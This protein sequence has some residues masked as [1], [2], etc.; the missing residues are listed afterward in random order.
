V[1]AFNVTDSGDL[2]GRSIYLASL[3]SP[4]RVISRKQMLSAEEWKV[5]VP[6]YVSIYKHLV[7]DYSRHYLFITDLPVDTSNPSAWF[8]AI[9]RLTEEVAEADGSVYY[10]DHHRTNRGFADRFSDMEIMLPFIWIQT[11]TGVSMSS[12]VFGLLAG[13]TPKTAVPNS[14]V[15]EYGIRELFGYIGYAE[16]WS[17]ELAFLSLLLL[18]GN[19]ADIDRPLHCGEDNPVYIKAVELLAESIL[20][21]WTFRSF[22]HAVRTVDVLYKIV[23]LEDDPDDFA[24]SVANTLTVV[25]PFEI[26]KYQ[27]E[28]MLSR[29][30][31]TTESVIAIG[32]DWCAPG[33]KGCGLSTV[34]ASRRGLIPKYTVSYAI[35]Y[36]KRSGNWV[37]QVSASKNDPCTEG[38]LLK[39]ME[40]FAGG[41]GRV[42]G[43][44]GIAL[45][46]VVE[47]KSEEEVKSKIS[48]DELE[49]L[50]LKIASY[51]S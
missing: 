42:V 51:L 33:N 13:Y 6:E 7:G 12:A 48:N 41:R 47:G 39:L 10:V 21:R 40:E 8:Q 17:P 20:D 2:H 14:G 45:W 30:V 4:I 32:G 43:H 3:Y 23:T 31:L 25:G 29:A 5:N 19:Y 9:K 11:D 36:D 28:H 50:A 16:K 27:A 38:D 24:R 35:K 22:A 1:F 15:A 37:A 26:A 46:F 49:K 44:P 34:L 18:A